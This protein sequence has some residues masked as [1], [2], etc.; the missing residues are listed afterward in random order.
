MG[1]KPGVALFPILSP[2]LAAG[3]GAVAWGLGH[4][5]AHAE[6]SV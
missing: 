1:I 4:K 6:S 5:A 2:S 3:G